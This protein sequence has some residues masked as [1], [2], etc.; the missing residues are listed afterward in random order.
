M[1]FIRKFIS[2]ITSVTDAISVFFL[3][4]C[5]VTAFL[6]AVMRYVFKM[7]LHFSE[8]LCVIS[9]ICIVFMSLPQLER[10]NDHL[11]MTALYNLFSPKLK[12]VMGVFRSIITIAISAWLAKAGIDVVLRNFSMNNK[13]QVLDWPY[14]IIYTVIPIAF[15]VIILIRLANI[16]I[17]NDVESEE[18]AKGGAE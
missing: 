4:V 13:T 11:S 16:T 9:L 12:T 5:T 8:E 17:K 10:N 6:N 2:T 1:K 18:E 7:P 14:G 3:C 15:V